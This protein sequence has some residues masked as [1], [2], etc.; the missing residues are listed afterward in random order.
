MKVRNGF[1]SNSSSQSFVVWGIKVPVDAFFK[2]FPL[3]ENEKKD[4]ALDDIEF[5]LKKKLGK[6]PEGFGCHTDR[7]YFGGTN[8]EIENI[9]VGLE[10]GELCDGAFVEIK[11]ADKQEISNKLVDMGFEA[12][13]DNISLFVKMVSNDNY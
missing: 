4:N 6:I 5:Y 1:V 10:E 11:C 2:L 12:N 13:E 8:E 3:G 7:Y 9:F